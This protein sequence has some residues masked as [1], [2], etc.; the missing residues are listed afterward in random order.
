MQ[1]RVFMQNR[2]FVSA[3]FYD[4]ILPS[5]YITIQFGA[6]WANGITFSSGAQNI[7]DAQTLL[8]ELLCQPFAPSGKHPMCPI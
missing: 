8:C 6:L 7:L 2:A 1:S 4:E 5:V 3:C